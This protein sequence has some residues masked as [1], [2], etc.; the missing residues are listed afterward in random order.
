MTD[1][2]PRD[3]VEQANENPGIRQSQELAAAMDHWLALFDEALLEE[4]LA[5]AQRPLQA[6]LMLFREGALEVRAG[7]DLM[8]GADHPSEHIEKLWFRILYDAVEYWYIDRYGSRAMEA[9]GTAPLLG[10]TMIHGAPFLISVPAYRSKVETV[11]ET[12]WMYFEEGLGEGED[13]IK[14]IVNGPD[15]SRLDE[16]ARRAVSD[17]ATRTATVLR[18]VE[19]RRVTFRSDGDHEVQKLIQSTLFYLGQAAERLA[20]FRS[21]EIGPAWFDLQMA[22]EAALKAV[23]RSKSTKQPKIHPLAD[24]LTIAE[25]HGV[26][27]DGSRL[28]GWPTFTEIS[29]WRYGQGHPRSIADLYLA[30]RLTLDLVHESMNQIVP[31]MKP[32]FGLLI[33]YAP[34]KTK[35]ATGRFRE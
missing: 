6:L 20:S 12:S 16:G 18:F 29:D 11:G 2:T 4:G 30:Y 14:W 5:P 1:G 24:L 3:P 28:A 25:K 19:F 9:R 35:D 8:A 34:W 33:K 31:G 7:D 13:A 32:G 22:N 15:V 27:F 10:A 21:P 17:E 23:I 26:S